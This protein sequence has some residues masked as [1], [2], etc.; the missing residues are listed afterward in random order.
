MVSFTDNRWTV[1]LS[2][3]D[4]S[5]NLHDDGK[6]EMLSNSGQIGKNEIWY[7]IVASNVKN[8]RGKFPWHSDRSVELRHRGKHQK[9]QANKEIIMG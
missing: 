2:R 7:R 3:N 1:Q 8:I 9:N 4:H 6:M 5:E